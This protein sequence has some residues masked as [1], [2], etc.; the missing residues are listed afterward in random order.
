MPLWDMVLSS[1]RQ[2]HFNQ[3]S[4]YRVCIYCLIFT[5]WNTIILLMVLLAVGT[6]CAGI[7]VWL[8]ETE[9]EKKGGGERLEQGNL[10]IYVVF[11]PTTI[12]P[13]DTW[14]KPW[15]RLI[16]LDICHVWGK[17]EKPATKCQD[18]LVQFFMEEKKSKRS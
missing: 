7:C 3:A 13:L 12:F 18:D 1:E 4:F 2:E 10:G 14:E 17:Q 9:R 8:R 6:L 11:L 5:E 15:S 16:L